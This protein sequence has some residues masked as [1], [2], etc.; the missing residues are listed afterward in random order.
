M[1][2]SS[3]RL[4]SL[5]AASL[6]L[7]YCTTVTPPLASASTLPAAA[8]GGVAWPNTTVAATAGGKVYTKVCDASRFAERGLDM[9]SFRYCDA[10]LPYAERVRDLIGWMTVEEKV[11]NL[12]DLSA[13]APRVGLPPYRWWAEALHG[14]ASTG[15]ATLFDDVGANNH[16]GRAAVN[17]ATVFA[18]VINS[19]ASFNETLW[20]SIGQASICIPAVSTE[21]RAMYN[22]GKGGLTYWSPN[23]NVVRDPRWGRALETPG[24]DPY[25]VGRYAVNFVRGMQDVPGHDAGAGDDPFSRPIKT[26]T[27]CKHYAAYDLDN[28]L[29]HTRFHYD[30]RVTERDMAETFLRP[31]EMCVREGD[32]SSVMCSFNL[33]NGVP[34]CTDARLLSQTIRGDWGLHGYIVSD[35]DAVQVI[36]EDVRWLNLTGAEASAAAIRAGLDLD[37]GQSWKVDGDGRMIGD[38][39]SNFSLAAV[40]QGKLRESD[41]DNALRNQFM[42]LMRVGYFDDIPQYSSLN[43]TDICTDEHKSLALD[44]ARQGIVLLKNHGNLLPLD[45]KKVRAVALHGPHV[46][47]PESVMDGGYTGKPSFTLLAVDMIKHV[48]I[49]HHAKTTI[50]VGGI[51]LH[52][53]MEGNDRE[54]LL[55]PRNQTEEIL[56]AAA[57]S[58]NPIVLVLLSGGG[59][60]VSFAHNHPKIGAILWAGYPGGEGGNAIAD[61][62]FGRYNPGG[63]LPLT[64]YKNKYIEQIPMTSMEFRPVAKHGYPGRTYKFYSGPEV[65]Y[66]FGY[67]LSYTKFLYETSCNGT[68]VTMPVAGHHCK[69]LSYHRSA[70]SSSSALPS[71]QAINVDGHACTETVSFNVSV[72][73]GGGRDG[74]HAVLVYTAPPPEVAEA[75]IK[76][77]AA[78]RRVFVPAGSTVTETF[79]LN[80]CRA[81]GIVERTAYTVVPSGVSTVLVQNVDSSVSFPVKIEFSV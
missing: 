24:E 33:V 22:L 51:N 11:A 6:L 26:S 21:A 35:C 4:L 23:I 9:S 42:T 44:G 41:I 18:N 20:K 8:A 76:Q 50:Y 58:P 36:T 16:F 28:W 13:G 65:L 45:P 14:V 57:R 72:T 80:V 49:A 55:L 40:A 7:L 64:W 38:F 25:V 2:S 62:I 5:A 17:N 70:L 60:D 3:S 67:G 74:A 29:N 10:S 68:T 53:E 56:R 19:A 30:A 77:V 61:V 39:L 81:F 78:F 73:N 69:G 46:K 37:C 66:P 63:R 1:A 15:P 52:I 34:A 75:P 12:G 71:C 54:D 32:A 43:E 48:K 79:T 27:C 47:A 59:L 31:F